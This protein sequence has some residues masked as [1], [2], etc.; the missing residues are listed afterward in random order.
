MRSSRT[1]V[2]L[3]PML[4]VLSRDRRVEDIDTDRSQVTPEAEM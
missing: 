4:G 2:A 1:R 3:T